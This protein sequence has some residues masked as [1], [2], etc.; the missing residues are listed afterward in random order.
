VKDLEGIENIAE[1]SMATEEAIVG[2]VV[3]ALLPDFVERYVP[4]LPYSLIEEDMKSKGK[5]KQY[6]HLNKGIQ[7]VESIGYENA[8][9]M[10]SNN[11]IEFMN[12]LK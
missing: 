7:I 2:G 9:K 1:E 10:Y 12:L 6:R 4:N 8:L 3:H 11:S 5:L